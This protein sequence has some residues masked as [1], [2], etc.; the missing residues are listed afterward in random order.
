LG[1]PLATSRLSN[2]TTKFSRS[3]R[4]VR[5]SAALLRQG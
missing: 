4:P 1:R 2:V 5:R 3:R